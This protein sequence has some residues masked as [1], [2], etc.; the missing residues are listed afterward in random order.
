MG[1]LSDYH[2]FFREFRR[3]FHHTG[4]VMPSTRFLA[5]ELARPLL[6]ERPPF[7]VLECGPGTGSVTRCLL[8]HLRPGDRFDAV[9]LNPNFATLLEHR[10]ESDPDFLIHRDKIRILQAAVQ[11]VPGVAVYDVIVSGL[12]LANFSLAEIRSVFAAYR[13]LLKPTGTL[14]YFEYAFLRRLRVPFAGRAGRYH[15]LRKG[16]LLKRYL[17]RHQL[18]YSSIWLNVPPAV[19]RRLRFTQ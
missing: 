16:R 14:S 8:R 2:R 18:D 19:V 3:D 13:R 9:E 10:L 15:L 5:R 4:A 7:H 12:P 11:D 1:T 17:D 6:G